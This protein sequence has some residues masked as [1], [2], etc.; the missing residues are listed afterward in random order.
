[1]AQRGLGNRG[2]LQNLWLAP[3]LPD[4]T[5][6][7][8]I[9][10]ERPERW[11]DEWDD[12]PQGLRDFAID[13][14]PTHAHVLLLGPPGCGKG[15]LARILHE[16]SPRAGRPLVPH[17]CGVFTESLA[18]A[19]LFGSVKGAYTGATGA[20]SG[21]VEAAS[22]GTLFLDELGALPALIQP[23]LLTFLETGEFRRMG[24]T[25]VRRAD[26]RVIAATNR[27][28]GEAVGAGEFRED[29]VGRLPIRYEV[30]PL[31]E[32]RREIAGIVDRY[33]VAKGYSC[34]LSD[35]ALSELWSHD[36]PGNIRELVSVIDYCAVVAKDG[37]IGRGHVE[38]GIRTQRIGTMPRPDKK[39]GPARPTSVEEE[40]REL[41]E[42]LEATGGN[43]SE[44][45]KL[46]GI[47]RST[48]YRR[49]KRYEGMGGSGE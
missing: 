16:L 46:Q 42:A 20:T 1:M 10:R 25:T 47:H 34:Q 4:T 5:P 32:R 14:G 19:R 3:T 29:L 11:R 18:E 7:G 49:L 13:F 17:N 40:R 48:L 22:G 35:D 27:K 23:M 30:P 2:I 43:K 36:W 9:M 41:V 15:Y 8:G 24:S 33:L 44:A 28:L 26:V 38:N 31:R 6:Q 37:V 45:A 21:L 39:D 12:L